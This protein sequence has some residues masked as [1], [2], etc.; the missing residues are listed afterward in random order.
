MWKPTS[1]AVLSLLV[2]T[3]AVSG[4]VAP[5]TQHPLADA[6]LDQ[7]VSKGTAVL[8]DG[9]GS[10][11]PDGTIETYRWTI[12]TPND[13]TVAPDCPECA[14][15]TFDPTQVGTYRVTLN[16]TDDDGNSRSDYLLVEV[17]P[18]ERPRIELSGAEQP[19]V[20]DT[21]T[22]TANL[23]A[24]SAALD[25]VVW[26]IGGVEIANHSLSPTQQTDTADKLF[27]TPGERTIT[28][29]VYDADGQSR[30]DSMQVSVQAD[31]PAS[32]DPEQSPS[33]NPGSIADRNSPTVNGDRTITGRK[34]LRGT[35]SVT[36]DASSGTVESIEW[37]TTTGTL[38]GGRRLT[39]TWSPGDHEL[40]AVVTYTDGS[41]NVATFPDGETTVVADSRPTISITSRNRYGTISGT[42]SALDEY[43]NLHDVHVKVDGQVVETSF[44][45]LRGR[46]RLDMDR[47]QNVEFSKADFVPGEEYRVTVVATDGRGQ[48]ARA[49]QTIVPVKKPEVVKSKFVNGPMDS[50]H[51]RIDAERYAAHHVLKID[52]NGV[53][54][55]EVM[56]HVKS[57]HP[58]SKELVSG[59]YSRVMGY[60]R[61]SD[62]LRIDSY[63]AAEYPGKYDVEA[64]ISYSFSDESRSITNWSV[65]EVTPSKPEI[66][67][68][69]VNDGTSNIITRE[70][71]MIVDVS[72]SF[73]PDGTELKYIWTQGA[74]PIKPDNSTAKFSTYESAGLIVED[75]YD[76]RTS[77][78]LDFL[79]YLPPKIVSR[80]VVSEGPH[81]PN[82]TVRVQVQTQA[83]DFSKRTYEK[84]FQLG[85]SISNP[86]AEVVY[87]QKVATESD[88]HSG[89]TET[90]QRYVGVIEIPA[91]EL[92]PG[93]E[94]PSIT[95][96]NEKNERKTT[97][98]DFPEA[99]VLVKDGEFWTNVTVDNLT[100]TIE[101]PQVDEVVAES[102]Q[103]RME[104]FRQ[105]YQIKE[106][107]NETEYVLEKRVKVS[108]PQYRTETKNIKSEMMKDAF[109]QSSSNWYDR[110]TVKVQKSRVETSSEWYDSNRRQMNPKWHDSS[111]W[112]GE[113]TG[114]TKRVLVDPAEY[115]T[116]RKYEYDYRVEKTGTRTE[117]H[118]KHFRVRHTGTRTVEHCS[119]RF[120]CYTTTETYT[121]YT[122]ETY[123][124]TTTE[125]YTYYVTRTNTYWSLS[126]F[127]SNH[128]YT[129][130]S[131]RVKTEEAEYESRY[132]V[133]RKTRYTETVTRYQVGRDVLAEPAQYEWQEKRQTGRKM[134]ARKQASL[135]DDWRM[136]ETITSTRWLLSKQTGMKHYQAPY[137]ENESNVVKT[138]ATIRGDY[139]ERYYSAKRDRTVRRVESSSEQYENSGA[140]RRAEIRRILTR[141]DEEDCSQNWVCGQ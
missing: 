22:Y 99:D 71:G 115:Q 74:D 30:T 98:I 20:G 134:M 47:R 61:F 123:T 72:N 16:V 87:W 63:W 70:H 10:L 40:Y 75:D 44:G 122:T 139:V 73:D 42:V 56:A 121:Y 96:T 120:G 43:E 90:P 133:E 67:L 12:R 81:Y 78:H 110:G 18:G 62:I 130:Q 105:G 124:Y 77:E 55:E 13:T 138:S 91:S 97:T 88:G 50:Y 19:T 103:T 2:V 132:E 101:E 41:R 8:L 31:Q 85:I 17:S 58:E 126:K 107:Q 113:V 80:A 95:V 84:D 111:L 140:V 52:L 60:N 28:A 102:T 35:Y 15:T 114:Q 27:P 83:F 119:L 82:E 48:T 7:D 92:S 6:G 38:D 21:E 116:E 125:T 104:Y 131:R 53:E 136:G 32:E 26:T 24:G 51:P 141:D 117:T 128:D 45:S 23:G 29:T 11:D 108:D 9:T 5:T 34:P 89:A 65:L 37:R 79:A 76:L 54:R 86:R 129:G 49:S 64:E 94:L 4:V 36:L 14:R 68:E 57:Q 25:Y 118:T 112:N 137:F 127:D 59:P 33:P 1:V 39:H 100:Y 66:R 109:L 46:R 135:S 3:T 106:Q 93:S 69:V